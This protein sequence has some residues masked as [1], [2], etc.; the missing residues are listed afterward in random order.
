MGWAFTN[1][2]VTRAQKMKSQQM[3]NTMY[4]TNVDFQKKKEKKGKL[5]FEQMDS[6]IPLFT[7][8]FLL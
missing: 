7:N 4:S 2:H 8:F 1:Y 5:F 3:M 6:L